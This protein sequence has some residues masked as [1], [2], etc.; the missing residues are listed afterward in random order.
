MP[1]GTPVSG[2]RPGSVYSDPS[3]WREEVEQLFFRQWICLGREEDLP[4]A[5]SFFTRALG[6]ESLL[7]VRDRSGRAGAFFN[8]CR[9]RG[10]LVVTAASGFAE[11]SF[12]CPY[13]AWSYDLEGRLL[14]APHTSDAPS[15][16]RSEL[17]LHRLPLESWG[18]F[19]FGQLSPG[20]GSL[21]E[22][23]GD[24]FER[25]GRYRFAD[26]RR[27][28]ARRYEVAA[29]WKILVENFSECYHCAP[30]HPA[31][32][33]LTP[34]TTGANDARLRRGSPGAKF[35]G[36]YMEFAPGFTSMTR[37]GRTSRAP[38]P[39]AAEIDRGRVYYYLIFPN[40]F[41]SLH[42]D[43]L[44]IHRAWPVAP[45]RTVVENEFYFAPDAVAHPGFDPSDAID[46]WDEVNRQDW[47]VCELAQQ[48]TRS[49]AWDGPHYSEREELVQDFDEFVARTM[50]RTP[51]GGPAPGAG[52]GSGG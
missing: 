33:R 51:H 1:R 7:L 32:N 28:G 19:L 27:G 9:H 39:G 36:G 46:L 6:D 26:L 50:G 52:A 3:A 42:P 24:F 41:F 21:A 31:L 16:D 4:R 48:G 43:Y 47:A 13:H 18:G 45:E 10:S 22:Q 25:F 11:R 15:F 8:V 2:P 40:L 20:H 37:T 49:R 34:Y 23:L 5:G 38:L 17:G 12:V 14:A 30:V 29:N 44:M 35:S